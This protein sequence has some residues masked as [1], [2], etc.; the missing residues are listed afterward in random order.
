MCLHYILNI[1]NL[2]YVVLEVKNMKSKSLIN[3]A[4][5]GA[6]CIAVSVSFVVGSKAHQDDFSLVRSQGNEYT[7]IMNKSTLYS[8]S[9]YEEDSNVCYRRCAFFPMSYP[10]NYAALYNNSWEGV[11]PWDNADHLFYYELPENLGVTSSCMLNISDVGTHA[12]TTPIYF[13]RNHTQK[14]TVPNFS[15]LTKIQFTTG[16]GNTVAFNKSFYDNGETFDISGNTITINMG[17]TNYDHYSKIPLLEISSSTSGDVDKKIVIDEVV[18]T[19]T[20]P[21]D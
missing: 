15:K 1:N 9:Y 21:G 7:L 11:S 14:I 4:L 3:I 18:L 2:L 16:T 20:C 12:A 17:S 5:I 8:S 10:G 13:D 6:S 19:Y